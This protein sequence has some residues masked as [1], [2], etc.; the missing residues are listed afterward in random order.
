M[1]KQLIADFTS[2]RDAKCSDAEDER[3]IRGAIAGQEAEIDKLVKRLVKRGSV[4]A[5]S[6]SLFIPEWTPR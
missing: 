4:V 3:R 1:R 6:S 5:R 2:V